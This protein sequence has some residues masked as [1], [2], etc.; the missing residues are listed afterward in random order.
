[1]QLGLG[2]ARLAQNKLDG[3][4]EAFRAYAK[5]SGAA[6]QAPRALYSASVALH[7]AEKYAGSDE[8]CSEFL[9]AYEHNEL[10]L[11]SCS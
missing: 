11:K 8:V 1:M 2:D 9:K 4:A 5:T 10:A 3:A 6:D 7:R